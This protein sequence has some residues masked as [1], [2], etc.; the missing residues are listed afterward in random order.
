MFCYAYGNLLGAS[1]GYQS[2]EEPDESSE[3]HRCNS[4]S[5]VLY[6]PLIADDC[7]KQ[8]ML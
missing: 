5:A 7:Y 4:Y 3:L 2:D 6:L 8:Y 1:S